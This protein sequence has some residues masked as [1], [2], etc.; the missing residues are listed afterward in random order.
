MATALMVEND[1]SSSP[2]RW[3]PWLAAAG[4]MPHVVRAHA[5]ASVPSRL[6]HDA[7]VV[8]GGAFMPDD[9]ERAPWL[10]A[11]R[12]LVAE[13]LERAVPCF[14]ICLGGQLLA[15]H[16]GGEVRPS[17]GTPEFGSV[18][19]TLRAEAADDPLFGDLPS[20]VAAIENHIDQIT[21]LPAEAVWLASSDD[22]PHQAFR[23]GPAAWGV[24]FHPESGAERIPHWNT[25]R[26]AA[27]GADR[28]ALHHAAEAAEPA[29]A[30]VWQSVAHRFA[31]LATGGS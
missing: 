19:L 7:L 9:E 28:D 15:Q 25:A 21:R 16:A 24:Q 31:R 1:Q 3:A 22:C 29:S 10:P 4:V 12:T 17:Y 23:L 2:G 11:V 8:L 14:G 6:E 5:G 27:H 26:L 30:R 13:A 20:E 18:P